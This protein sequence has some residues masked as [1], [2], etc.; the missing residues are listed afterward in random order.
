MSFTEIRADS[1]SSQIHGGGE[2]A[3]LSGTGNPPSAG[4]DDSGRAVVRYS[5]PS[6]IPTESP[7]L[8]AA[9][10]RS[11]SECPRGRS[12]K[13]VQ[14][15]PPRLFRIHSPLP[16][17]Q[18][19]P[20][21]PEEPTP[22]QMFERVSVWLKHEINEGNVATREGALVAL[23]RADINLSDTALDR[24][25]QHIEKQLPTVREYSLDR[26]LTK[27]A[28]TLRTLLNPRSNCDPDNM[29]AS[30]ICDLAD[31]RRALTARAG[32]GEALRFARL[33]ADQTLMEMVE[34]LGLR[35]HTRR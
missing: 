10:S 13:R 34:T 5:P 8:G 33:V 18:A 24:V 9:R 23:N 22:K 12:V 1:I 25:Q 17:L 32:S 3:A 28:P 2:P 31:L 35:F 30:L 27:Y 21:P 16:M 4:R 26:A 29:R 7:V 19:P 11:T 6:P 14:R 20:P 15:D